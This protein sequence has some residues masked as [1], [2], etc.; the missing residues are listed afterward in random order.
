MVEESPSILISILKKKENPKNQTFEKLE[1]KE[2]KR[3]NSLE[4]EMPSKASTWH[5]SKLNTPEA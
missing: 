1:R 4:R 5:Q 3:E 2:Y